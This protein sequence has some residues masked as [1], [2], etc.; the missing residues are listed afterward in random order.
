MKLGKTRWLL[1][2]VLC[3]AFW[4][5]GCSNE[6]KRWEGLIAAGETA[7][8]AGRYAEAEKLFLAALKE[9]EEFGEQDPRLATSLNNLAC[10][11]A[12]Q[13]KF[14]QAALLL[15]RALAIRE[16]ALGPEHPDLATDLNNL[17]LLY[18]VHG[19]YAQAEPLYRRAL[20]IQGK[21]LGPEHPQIARVLENYAALLHKLNRE[22][23][24]D[25]MEARAQ[26]VRAKHAK[27]NPRE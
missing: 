11:Y 8:Q 17:A 20:A 2:G 21:A 19:K 23:E 5:A 13:G 27:E 10:L 26:A 24:A 3:L 1:V 16:K 18:Y 15:R 9:A 22:A 7:Y 25:K 4:L 14:A 6:E 12:E